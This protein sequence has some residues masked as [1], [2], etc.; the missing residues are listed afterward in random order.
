MAFFSGFLVLLV[1]QGL[2]E[3][4]NETPGAMAQLLPL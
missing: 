2:S 4:G 1:L 3:K